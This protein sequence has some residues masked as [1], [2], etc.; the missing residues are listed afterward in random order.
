MASFYAAT[1]AAL[2]SLGVEIDFYD[3]PVE[4]AV[5]IPFPED[6]EHHAYDA[7]AVHRY[8]LALLQAHRVMSIFRGRFVGKASPVHYFWGAGDLAATRFSG[9]P[10]PLH[11]GGVPNCP[12]IVQVL[13]YDSELSSCGFWAGGSEEGSFYAYSYP[14]PDGFK[15]WQVPG[16]GYYDLTFSEFLLPYKEVRTSPD[17]DSVLLN[18]L[19]S[20]YEAAA[21][22]GKWDRSALEAHATGA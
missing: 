21:E 17:P 4:V 19:Q 22:L 10:A 7:D 9:R 6:E 8:W 16:P 13:A 12:D 5:A 14:E 2:D 1:T 18:F 20:T 3:R 15:D 11:P